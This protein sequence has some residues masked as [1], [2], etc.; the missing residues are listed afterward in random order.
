MC[1]KPPKALIAFV[2]AALLLC[3]AT[4]TGTIFHQADV[5]EQISQLQANLSAVQGRL[6]KQQVEY[7]QALEALPSVQ[8]ELDILQPQA[9]AAYEQEQLLRQQRKDLRAE[10]AA[11]ADELAA[12]QADV[13]AASAAADQSAQAIA[14]VQEALENLRLI[15]GLYE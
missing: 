14:H 15:Y 12:L 3:S 4:V 6:R 8:A 1:N 7:A 10:N 13:N 2:V 9:D 11:L 5:L